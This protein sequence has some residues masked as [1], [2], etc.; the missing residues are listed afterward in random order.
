MSALS[1]LELISEI[2]KDNTR[3][4]DML[5]ERFYVQLCRVALKHVRNKEVSEEIVQ[6]VFIS[7]WK[8]RMTLQIH[9]SV[10]AYLSTAIKYR[11]INHIKSA[12]RK[13]FMSP[14]IPEYVHSNESS[15]EDK[16][17]AD[18]LQHMLHKSIEQLPQK[19]RVIFELSRNT[20][21]SYKEIAAELGVSIK[22]VETQMSI[23]LARLRGFLKFHAK[24][25]ITWIFFIFFSG[26]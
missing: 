24:N 20:G 3:A 5:V 13:P 9:E 7:I 21:M 11:C 18:D 1:D 8:N 23:A 10:A 22:T 15:V 4:L 19:C 16:I 6:D 12:A 17:A 25:L 26:Y 2:S 14:E